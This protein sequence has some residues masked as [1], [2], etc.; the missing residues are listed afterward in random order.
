MIVCFITREKSFLHSNVNDSVVVFSFSICDA[1]LIY[2]G[3]EVMFVD[4]NS[5]S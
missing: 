4:F 1:K 3:G 2:R 5:E